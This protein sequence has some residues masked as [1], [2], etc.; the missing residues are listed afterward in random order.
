[1]FFC[2]CSS[3]FSSIKLRCLKRYY[4]SKEQANLSHHEPPSPH[5]LFLSHS[6]FYSVAHFFVIVNL[7]FRKMCGG[8][9]LMAFKTDSILPIVSSST[10]RHIPTF[11]QR[12]SEWCG[13]CLLF[14]CL[15]LT[16]SS[17]Q[18][19]SPNTFQMTTIT[20]K[21]SMMWQNGF[22]TFVTVRS[23]TTFIIFNVF[24]LMAQFGYL[25]NIKWRERKKWARNSMSASFDINWKKC[26]SG[27]A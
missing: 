12:P 10:H 23:L 2:L 19:A 21:Q 9:Y 6:N 5:W 3:F 13:V 20:Q 25:V 18:R 27:L 8:F 1:M 22:S 14:R 17:F 16:F 7:P 15:I 4:V 24:N 11:T 26:A